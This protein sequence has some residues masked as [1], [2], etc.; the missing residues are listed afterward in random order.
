MFILQEKQP[1]SAYIILDLITTTRPTIINIQD[2]FIIF[3]FFS[4]LDEETFWFTHFIAYIDYGSNNFFFLGFFLLCICFVPFFLVNLFIGVFLYLFFWGKKKNSFI[5]VFCNFVR[6][7]FN[8]IWCFFVVSYKIMS[9]ILR[10]CFVLTVGED[11]F[12][13]ELMVGWFHANNWN[14]TSV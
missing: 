2:F 7:L 3:F 6:N 5:E 9:S 8:F 1:K 4:L 12:I 14:S 13:I 11:F 10:K